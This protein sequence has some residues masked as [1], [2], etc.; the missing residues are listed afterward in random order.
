ML[1]FNAQDCTA[2]CRT[3]HE[4]RRLVV[5]CIA[6]DDTVGH[7]QRAHQG[8]AAKRLQQAAQ[9]QGCMTHSHSLALAFSRAQIA[10]CVPA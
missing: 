3:A 10:G 1:C 7:L 4:R 9:R 5:G 6:E 2:E 8:D